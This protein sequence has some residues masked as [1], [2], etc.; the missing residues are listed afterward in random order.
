MTK[1]AQQGPT[2]S[3]VV[4][5]RNDDYCETFGLRFQTFLR[6]LAALD[7]QY[8][9]LFELIV[10]EW[11]PPGDRASMADA[12]DWSD[13]P[14]CRLVTVPGDVHDG[15]PNPGRMPMLEFMA[16][17]VGVRRA[18]TPFVLSTNPDI[19]LSPGFFSYIGAQKLDEGAYYRADRY[20]FAP[21][22]AFTTPG[23]EICDRAI[24]AV[25]EVHT[26]NTIDPE[27]P[28]SHVIDPTEPMELWPQSKPFYKDKIVENG[29]AIVSGVRLDPISGL[30]T[31]GSGDFIM[32]HK[33]AWALVRGHWERTD[34][35]SHLDSYLVCN[36]H[37]AGIRQRILLRPT[38][39]LHMNHSR[40]DHKVRPVRPY[41]EAYADFR[42]AAAGELPNPNNENWGLANIDLPD[43][44][45][46]LKRGK[47]IAAPTPA[48]S[49]TDKISMANHLRELNRA[50]ALGAAQRAEANRQVIALTRQVAEMHAKLSE[51]T[52]ENFAAALAR[53]E[54]ALLE[55][56]ARRD[57]L[58]T[59]FEAQA[60]A[61]AE[62]R[63]QADA[64]A[65]AEALLNDR[66]VQ[67]RAEADAAHADAQEA[68]AEAGAACAEAEAARAA[69]QALMS[70][71]A[72]TTGR[73]D[74]IIRLLNT[75]MSHIRADYGQ[76]VAGL[77]QAERLLFEERERRVAGE[78][79]LRALEAEGVER[80]QR[81]A[82]LETAFSEQQS[83][84]AEYKSIVENSRYLRLRGILLNI[85]KR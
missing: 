51:S 66:L 49:A 38:L 25:F 43:I 79:I 83:M 59:E 12:F 34:T 21:E 3:I 27:E 44:R 41:A 37:G 30:H 52:T 11:N 56:T 35:C 63:A 67:L 5:G 72:D 4:S 75:E 16:K 33:N 64:A 77:A 53:A 60:Q 73:Y 61:L 7:E 2:L 50:N 62:H 13:L 10:V 84:L 20:D 36:F 40:D 8:K 46:G 68:C 22:I 57:A 39:V 48:A 74:E 85:L 28:M 58:Q 15:I 19:I 45:P 69:A 31:Q 23:P 81:F 47:T 71:R 54:A 80:E 26:R 82:A 42:K 6:H 18:S 32:A 17:N 9:S 76:R 55:I 29:S 70:E 24:E 14:N 78:V 1:G 65:A